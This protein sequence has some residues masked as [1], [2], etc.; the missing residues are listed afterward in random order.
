MKQLGFS[1]LLALSAFQFPAAAQSNC[2]FTLFKI[3]NYDTVPNRIDRYGNVVGQ[4]YNS[5]GSIIG[6]IRSP[7][8]GIIQYSAPNSSST[9]LADRNSKAVLLGTFQ[10]TTSSHNS[11]GFTLSFN[12][13]TQ[14]D[15]PGGSN[16]VLTGINDS[17]TIVGYYLDASNNYQG[18][19]L[20]AGTFTSI[21]YP[22]ATST[23]PE[24]INNL[25][26]ITGAYDVNG[27]NT[28]GFVLLNGAY[29]QLNN[30]SGVNGT[31]LEGN[32]AG[33]EIVGVYYV[34]L[35]VPTQ[36]FIYRS[37]VFSNIVVP[38]ANFDTADGVNMFGVI[39]GAASFSDGY[40]GYVATHCQ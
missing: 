39:T 30:P 38:N 9:E 3:P 36:G 23:M 31:F 6:F 10:D 33:E 1:F 8:G 37:N 29:T 14:I 25:G 32:N 26:R 21:A 7:H 20:E 15:Y 35:A 40:H 22:G 11:H 17:G 18:F 2:N 16:T 13:F 24:D 34:S 4:A 28:N 27:G 5:S 12:T 19:Q